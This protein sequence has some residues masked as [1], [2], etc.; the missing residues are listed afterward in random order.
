MANCIEILYYLI[1][2]KETEIVTSEVKGDPKF[3]QYTTKVI[4]II[5]ISLI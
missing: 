3:W 2:I 1:E 4:A 5:L